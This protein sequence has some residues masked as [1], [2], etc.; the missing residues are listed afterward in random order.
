MSQIQKLVVEH[1]AVNA[2]NVKESDRK[3]FATRY[4]DYT[5]KT[6]ALNGNTGY[7]PL[8]QHHA[9]IFFSEL[10]PALAWTSATL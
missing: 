9:S 6:L 5:A 4:Q 10:R 2:T 3:L 7:Q 1:F 8:H